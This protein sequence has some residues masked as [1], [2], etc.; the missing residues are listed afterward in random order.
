MIFKMHTFMATSQ[1]LNFVSDLKLAHYAKVPPRHAFAAQVYATLLAGFAALGVNHWVLAN[2]DGVC[3]AGQ[4]DRFTCPHTHSYFLSSVLWG[5]IGPRRI[6]GP[7]AP[8]NVVTWFAP[9]GLVLPLVVFAAARR[10]PRSAWRNVN[11]PVLLAGQLGWAPYNWT[12]MQGS[13]VL[14]LFFNGFLKRRRTAWWQRYAY[15]L[16]ASF[17]A[18]IGVAGLVMFFGLQQW[19]VRVRWWGNSVYKQGV[20]FGGL[21]DSSGDVVRC[22]NLAMPP[23][24][25]RSA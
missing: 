10:W 22:A 7:G 14:A 19:D 3:E 1:S 5:V 12:Y 4:P 11:A 13:L 23:G 15:V 17:T 6:F 25:I 24:G 20:D 2:I 9:V 8:Y 18:A 21:R 16:S